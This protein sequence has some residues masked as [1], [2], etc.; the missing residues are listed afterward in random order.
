M[1]RRYKV[2]V[3]VANALCRAAQYCDTESQAE[4]LRGF[5]IVCRVPLFSGVVMRLVFED[6]NP[7]DAAVAAPPSAR[8]AGADEMPGIDEITSR[9]ADTEMTGRAS[10]T[11]RAEVE[12]RKRTTRRAKPSSNRVVRVEYEVVVQDADL[13]TSIGAAQASAFVHSAVHMIEKAL[14][15]IWARPKD[16]AGR[17][18]KDGK[19]GAG[20]DGGRGPPPSNPGGPH[21]PP[22]PASPPEPPQGGGAA[23]GAAGGI[24][25]SGAPS[26]TTGR[27]AAV[28]NATD[29][30]A[31]EQALCLEVA[32]RLNVDT[33]D[34]VLSTVRCAITE[35]VQCILVVFVAVVML[36]PI[37][38]VLSSFMVCLSCRIPIWAP[39]Y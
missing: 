35:F 6:A 1:L 25:R 26:H 22:G 39:P 14:I 3:M 27:K 9:L 16:P 7:S 30:D 10:A 4:Q 2:F 36:P 37:S 17:D 38:V 34:T 11:E 12:T 21:E 5:G 13:S 33:I 32:S 18:G 24:S 19:D 31:R 8:T 28:W 29:L 23:D 20:R 15:S